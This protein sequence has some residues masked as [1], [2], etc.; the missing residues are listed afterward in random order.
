MRVSESRPSSGPVNIFNLDTQ[1]FVEEQQEI[2]K[3]ISNG[4]IEV[5]FR[6]HEYININSGGNLSLNTFIRTQRYFD[7]YAKHNDLETIQISSVDTSYNIRNKIKVRESA[8]S[9]NEGTQNIYI[10][11]NT[12]L[13]HDK[14]KGTYGIRIAS[15][16]ETPIE[17]YKFKDYAQNM[18][19]RGSKYKRIKNRK[20][21]IFKNSNGNDIL[22]LDMT[23]VTPIEGG[24]VSLGSFEL[25]VELLRLEHLNETYYDEI[26]TILN[27]VLRVIQ[28]SKLIYSRQQYSDVIKFVNRTLDISSTI[29]NYKLTIK[30][31]LQDASNIRWNDLKWGGIVGNKKTTYRVTIKLDGLRKLLVFF[32]DSMWLVYPPGEVE[33]ISV[34]SDNMRRSAVELKGKAAINLNG[35]I[36]EGE[37]IKTSSFPDPSFNDFIGRTR[38]KYFYAHGISRGIEILFYPFDVLSERPTN[39]SLISTDI[40][41]DISIQ[42]KSHQKRI[43]LIDYVFKKVFDGSSGTFKIMPKKFYDFYDTQSM[44]RIIRELDKDRKILPVN[45]DGFIFVPNDVPYDYKI[46]SSYIQRGKDNVIH[47]IKNKYNNLWDITV[48]RKWKSFDNL[49]IDLSANMI[50]GK[51]NTF[52]G[53]NKQFNTGGRKSIYINPNHKLLQNTLNKKTVIEFMPIQRFDKDG[54][55]YIELKPERLRL[56]K[57]GP[58]SEGTALDVWKNIIDPISLDTLKGRTIRLMRKYHNRIKSS[59][60]DS[61]IGTSSK[62]ILDI[63]SGRG[64]DLNKLFNYK[65]SRY[66]PLFRKM[67]A[68][69]PN[70]DNIKEYQRRL[71]ER[72]YTASIIMDGSNDRDIKKII[73]ESNE[74]KG[75]IIIIQTGGENHKLI[76]KVVELFMGGKVDIIVFMLSLSFFWLG[77]KEYLH[78]LSIT[79]KNNLNPNGSIGFITI[80]GKMVDEYFFPPLGGV[81]RDNLNIHDGKYIMQYNLSDAENPSPYLNIYLEDT[82]VTKESS[83]FISPSTDIVKINTEDKVSFQK[84]G[85]TYIDDLLLL[86]PNY[87]L[88]D[89]YYRAD[90]E[91]FLSLGETILSS[92]YE[93]GIIEPNIRKD[94]KDLILYTSKQIMGPTELYVQEERLLSLEGS[95]PREAMKRIEY[96]PLEEEEEELDIQSISD[97]EETEQDLDL[98]DVEKEFP[99]VEEIP[100]VEE[101][102]DVEE[103]PDVDEIPDVEELEE[104]DQEQEQEAE[105]AS[106][107]FRSFLTSYLNDIISYV[108][109]LRT[110]Y[111]LRQANI[112]QILSMDEEEDEGS[113]IYTFKIDMYP[114]KDKKSQLVGLI[115][116][117]KYQNMFKDMLKLQFGKSYGRFV[118]ANDM[119]VYDIKF[120]DISLRIKDPKFTFS[121]KLRLTYNK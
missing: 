14:L 17:E 114:E 23:Q 94:G 8:I 10:E 84:E 4:E 21:Y 83:G 50:N 77:N 110:Q 44:F 87:K 88:S 5:E 33:C 81:I 71:E 11:K 120:E 108:D 75:R 74:N 56:D 121:I 99:D 109:S 39:Y 97:I 30:N 35:Y 96:V 49:T 52:V 66:I 89:Y 28:N 67:V 15:S 117:N 43:S 98:P 79:I 34:I 57:L 91:G 24:S 55:K 46:P 106:D 118:D 70:I 76:T 116:K 37:L 54:N 53:G 26:N 1:K 20:Q 27:L 58:N 13:L 101:F 63:G 65:Q 62:N 31:K 41:G 103:I 45:D 111:K 112:V 25:E 115:L 12:L 38:P 60:Y 73:K 113:Y 69:E 105:L 102:P 16:K 107:I 82:I 3:N 48:I 32:N 85:I 2:Q 104:L 47:N 119:L 100:D 51:I 36:L 95:K 7:E 72:G 64:G 6:F 22:S 78:G 61:L 90:Q 80:S 86:L 29:N 19:Y 68:V 42:K 92:M 59:I 40:R 9:D 18:N 93:Y